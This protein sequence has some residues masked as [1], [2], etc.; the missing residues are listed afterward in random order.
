MTIWK[1][2][3][4]LKDRQIVMMPKG[5]KIIA[6]QEQAGAICLWAIVDPNANLASRMF[7]IAGTGMPLSSHLGPESHLATVQIGRFVWHVFEG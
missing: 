3:L 5:A 2:T 7:A 6:I 1:F 4:E